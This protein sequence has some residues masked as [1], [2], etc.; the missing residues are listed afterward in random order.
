MLGLQGETSHQKA[1]AF[2]NPDG[3][4][5]LECLNT[6]GSPANLSVAV[7]DSATSFTVALP[8]H[9]FN[10]FILQA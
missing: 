2:R 8:A 5:V 9:S 10:T 6:A 1:V 4:I 7:T 3:Q